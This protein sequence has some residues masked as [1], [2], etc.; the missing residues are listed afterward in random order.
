MSLDGRRSGAD[1]P[2]G[3]TRRF[4]PSPH[5]P[6]A[7]RRFVRAALDGTDEERLEVAELLTGEL[8]TNVLLHARSEAEV[9]AGAAGGVV[10]VR[11][12][13]R[14]PGRGPLPSPGHPYA[15]TGWGLTMVE[16]LASRHG[17]DTY[18]DRK[19]VWFEL[20][21]D[22]TPPP[23]EVSAP[24]APAPP[25]DLA[26]TVTLVDL[27]YALHS[28]SRR[29][30]HSL[31]RELLLAARSGERFGVPPEDLVV[32]HDANNLISTCMTAALREQPSDADVRI[33]SLAVPTD[34]TPAV[35][36]LRHVVDLAE[37]AARRQRLLTRPGLPQVRA[38][39]RWLLDEIVGQLAGGHP[40]PWT[41]VPREPSARPSEPAPWDARQ[42]R[43]SR[44]P[45]LAADDG[46]RIIA[47]NA[48]AADLLGWP[49]DELIGQRITAL[50]PEHLRDRHVTAFTSLLLTGEPHILGRSVPLPAMHRDGG[51]VPVRLFVQTQEAADGRTVFVAQLIRRT[52][53]PAVSP[54]ISG[55]ELPSPSRKAGL[56]PAPAAAM[57][58]PGPAGT[59]RDDTDWTAMERLALLADTRSALT[60]APDLSTRVRQVCEILTGRL[61]DWCVVDLLDERDRARRLCVV[62]RDPG[63]LPP[64]AYE[65]ELPPVTETA[66][67]PLPRVLRGA[68][69]LLLTEV[70]R[71]DEAGSALDARQ[72]EMFEQLGANSAVVA[73][74]RTRGEVL[75]ALT[76][77]RISGQRPFTDEDLPLI[78]DVSGGLA[79]GI[80]NARLYHETR[81]IAERLQRSLLP[82]LPDIRHL[83]VAARYAPSSATAQVGGDWYDAFVLPSGDTVLVI[84]DVTGHDLKAAVAMSALRNMLRGI[85]IDRKEPP[86]D[87]LRRLDLAS[88]TLYQHATAT[89]VYALLKDGPAGQP[90]QLHHATA[91]HLPPLLVTGEGDTRY[92]DAGAGVLIGMDPELPRPTARDT[93][94]P[95]STL[96]L[97]TDGLIERRG[98][99]LD[100]AMNRLRQHAAA[101]AREPLDV[102]CD[103]LLI[104]LGA[105][106][107]D[108]IALLAVRPTPP[109]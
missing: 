48:P 95:Y 80:D 102:F 61:A 108:D 5:S 37:D 44:V 32:A 74:L 60:T 52:I 105:D 26:T 98:E 17:V 4:P 56:P 71:P 31:L 72:L 101:L 23:A 39:R 15:S 21:P 100:D 29:H 2:P 40:A 77:A 93:L 34:A 36:T 9:E 1:P 79:L 73:P 11:V 92:L 62:H 50:M 96:L 103:E 19:T 82:E 90:R 41:L 45:T 33:L 54:E 58:R 12:G 88:H 107:T 14:L 57:T 59:G 85:A 20:W 68:G 24:E 76:L 30:R 53:D 106:S 6:A 7:A 84:G 86:G 81:Q 83:G 65:G 18:Q 42:V 104:G 28:A 97:Y 91:G 47:A 69:P 35:I 89:C 63:A 10:R 22:G 49:L 94:P 43:Q 16:Q 64:E 70:P 78:A 75:G 109:S 67:G 99:S 87:V 55:E 46:N 25:S 27:P 13:D 3:R 8:V 38:F 66:R 51:L